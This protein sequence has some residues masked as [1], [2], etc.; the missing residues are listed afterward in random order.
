MSQPSPLTSPLPWNLVSDAYER[1]VRPMFEPFARAAL[2]LSAPPPRSRVVDVACGPGTLSV[3]AARAGHRVDALDFAPEMLAK[4]DARVRAEKLDG[5]TAHLGDGQSLPFEDASFAA[6]YSMFGLMFFPDRA[7]GFA[8]LARVLVPGARAVV[9]SWTPLDEVP[10]LKTTFETVM[11]A[12]GQQR[13]QLPAVLSN[14]TDVHAEM[15]ASFTDIAVH[16]VSSTHA[17]PSAR[18]AWQ[19][20]ERTLAPIVLM[21]KNTDPAT[22]AK[23]DTE[24]TR[25]LE[26]LLGAGP[27]H[28]TMTALLGVGVRA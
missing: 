19:S 23:V 27:V 21:K 11:S 25:A 12:L 7:K 10:A 20:L 13:P 18:A 28:F 9:S 4:L 17:E 1:E 24:V 16:R 6:G 15:S 3:L 2:E 8:E 22:W 14:E 26:A 5:I